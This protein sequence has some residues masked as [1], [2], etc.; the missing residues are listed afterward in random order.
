MT[1]TNTLK[2]I[3]ACVSL[4]ALLILFHA[5]IKNNGSNSEDPINYS[6][7]LKLNSQF[8]F[9]TMQNV[10]INIQI[11]SS[12][13]R[14]AAH[15][16]KIY[17]N[18]P[19][20]T[21]QL[22]TTGITDPSLLYTAVLRIP[23][24]LDT[25]WIANL[26]VLSDSTFFTEYQKVPVIAKK[27]NYAFTM[28]KP[29]TNH[30]SL[31]IDDPGCSSGCT[32]SVNTTVNTIQINDNEQVCLTTSFK[33]NITF[34]TNNSTAKLVICGLDTISN[35]TVNGNGTANIIISNSGNLTVRNLTMSKVNITN[36]GTFNVSDGITVAKDRIF[37]NYGLAIIDA[38]TITNG[39][40]NNNGNLN[41]SSE[42]NNSGAL[43]NQNSLLI[44]G[45]LT[46]NTNYS[47]VNE[48]R[49]DIYGNVQHYG[50]LTNKGYITVQGDVKLN[51]GSK[52]TLFAQS[53]INI[54][55]FSNYVSGQLTVNGDITG[56][57]KGSGN[58]TIKGKTEILSSAK[59]YNQIDICDNDGI[60][61]LQITLPASVTS[62][63]S[64]T[65]ATYCTPVSGQTSVIDTDADGVPDVLDDYPTNPDRA[66]ISYYPN[67]GTFA[68][69]CFADLWPFKGIGG[70]NDFV[71][72]FQ[73]QIITNSKNQVVDIYGIFHPKA[74]GAG[75]DNCFAVALPVPPSTVQIIEGTKTYGTNANDLI[76]L[77]QQGFETGQ[78]NNTV[79]PV[80]N[81]VYNYYNANY[82]VNVWPKDPFYTLPEAVNIHIKF[83][84]PIPSS[85]LIPPYNPFLIHNL[86]RSNE[87][88][89]IDH[90]PTEL[91]NFKTFGTGDD[92]SELSKGLYYRTINNLPWVIEIP[93]SFDYPNAKTDIANAYLKYAEWALSGG[94]KSKDWYLNKPG[95]RN[96]NNIYKNQ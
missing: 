13:P 62:C 48:C 2:I 14:P 44:Y 35:I 20:T 94:T 71:V 56:P 84:T 68:T 4:F 27:I 47:F 21:G 32:R 16:I 31:G 66:F 89:L 77:T 23:T 95:Y 86:I 26:S 80:I 12:D 83:K 5:C 50:N 51:L 59:F 42:I 53:N 87:I 33:G 82:Y 75:M 96:V 6:S 49:T 91:V 60:E 30:K 81:S 54:T 69:L 18:N 85:Q 39:T 55:G 24:A 61:N 70:M 7:N 57:T 88:H 25:V 72:D 45:S 10:D 1:K 40:T 19:G 17:D 46:N 52:T 28:L 93:V 8:N 41:I 3:L 37:T 65:P 67:Y 34:T 76:K 36:Y 15:V 11:Q 9:E 43:V 29:V 58:I 73:Y 64:Y 90:A 22:I 79:F 92:R 38:M 78:L 63:K 74:E